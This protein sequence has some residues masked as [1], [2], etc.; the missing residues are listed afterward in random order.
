MIYNSPLQVGSRN[1]IV[2][3]SLDVSQTFEDM[4]GNVLTRIFEEYVWPCSDENPILTSKT[5]SARLSH[6]ERGLMQFVQK[7]D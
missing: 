5:C 1:M 3:C 7:L 6:P 4:F 2:D